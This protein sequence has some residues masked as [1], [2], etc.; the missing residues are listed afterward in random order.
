MQYS[1]KVHVSLIVGSFLQLCNVTLLLQ[2][3]LSSSSALVLQFAV[4][5]VHHDGDQG[6]DQGWSLYRIL[7]L[8]L[9]FAVLHLVQTD[10]QQ[11]TYTYS[12]EW[13]TTTVVFEHVR[14]HI[15]QRT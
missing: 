13:S 3:L 7:V 10:C 5:A 15:H 2:T 1:N 8:V 9:H 14:I 4:H 6:S 11:Y 12:V